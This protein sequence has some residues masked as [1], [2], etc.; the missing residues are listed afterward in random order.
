[1]KG[2]DCLFLFP[3][4]GLPVHMKCTI[5]GT[6]LVVL[7]SLWSVKQ[8][9]KALIQLINSHLFFLWEVGR[10][11]KYTKNVNMMSTFPNEKK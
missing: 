6:S 1:M 3:L 2:I 8:H 10:D 5:L 4:A 11:S 9:K 7:T